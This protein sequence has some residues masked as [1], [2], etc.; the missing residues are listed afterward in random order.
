MNKDLQQDIGI[1]VAAFT[2]NQKRYIAAGDHKYFEYWLSAETELLA[3]LQDVFVR[4]KNKHTFKEMIF[5]SLVI[6]SAVK[7]TIE[8]LHRFVKENEE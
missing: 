2:E 5:F 4:H 7:G 1:S 6:G 8:D 3:T